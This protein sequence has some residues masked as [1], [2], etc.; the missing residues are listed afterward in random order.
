MSYDA[1]L[2]QPSEPLLAVRDLSITFGSVGGRQTRVLSGV[3]LDVR[4]GETT[5]LVG[6]SGS[7]KTVTSLAILG[8]LKAKMAHV[9]SGSIHFRGRDLLQLPEGDLARLRGSALSMIFQDPAASLNPVLRVGEQIC[10]ILR[11]HLGLQ[12]QPARDRAI[13]LLSEVGILEPHLRVSYYPHQLSGGQ[14]QRVMI[15]MAIACEPEL[16]IADEPTSALDV[17]VQHQIIALL[18]ELQARR[19]MALLFITH[20]LDL[21]AELAHETTVLECGVTAESGRTSSVLLAPTHE[22]TRRLLASRLRYRWASHDVA[23]TAVPICAQPVRPKSV[24]AGDGETIVE[25]QELGKDFC[26]PSGWFRTRTI[27]VVDEIS[28]RLRRGRTTGLIGESGAGKSTVAKMLLRLLA[29]SR[30]R[31][32]IDGTDLFQL[33]AKEMRKLRRRLQIVF[34]NPYA[35]L[36]PRRTVER[37]LVDPMEIHGIG[38][39]DSD[40]RRRAGELLEKVSLGSALL[41]RYP[42]ELSGGQRQRVAIARCIALQPDVLVCDE[43]VSALDVCTQAQILD[44][45]GSLQREFGTAYLFISHDLVSVRR[46]SDEILVMRDGKIVESGPTENVCSAPSNSY[47]RLLIDAVPRGLDRL[48]VEAACDGR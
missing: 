23:E 43:C 39:S 15:A 38:S 36:H 22:S 48:A 3:N 27:T 14:Q 35:S 47:T 45:L 2:M 20:D 33:P 4:R 17:T 16:L 40:R 44:L 34:Q 8:L 11:L 21:A 41:T 9:S 12:Q 24:L 13:E 42:A 28:F 29:P 6:E 19:R 31:V 26:L 1:Q 37:I 5:A 18:R 30:G 25:V 46:M 10:Q 7:G 32:L